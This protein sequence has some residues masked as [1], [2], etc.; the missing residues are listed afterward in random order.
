MNIHVQPT[1]A[2]C[3]VYYGDGSYE[4]KSSYDAVFTVTFL[5]DNSAFLQAGHGKISNQGYQLIAKQLEA[6]YGVK[7]VI[8]E[9][10]GKI[11]SYPISRFKADNE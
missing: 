5:W 10:H 9:R 3:R 4:S 11:V 6:D 1:Q 7:T 8:M 2:V